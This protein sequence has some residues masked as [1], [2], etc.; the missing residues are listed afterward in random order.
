MI[1]DTSHIRFLKRSN[2]RA[3][4]KTGHKTGWF[5]GGVLSTTVL[6]PPPPPPPPLNTAV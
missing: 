5:C 2:G 1:L 4:K 6:S 3:V